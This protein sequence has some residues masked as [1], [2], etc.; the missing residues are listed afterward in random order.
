MSDETGSDIIV[1]KERETSN[2]VKPHNDLLVI[3]L[4]IANIDVARILVNTGSS[5]DIVFKSTLERMKLT[6]SKIMESPIPLVGLSRET[7][8]TLGSI[9]LAVKAM[10]IKKVVEFLIIDCPASYN[11]IVGT[12]WLN[13]MQAILS[14]YHMFL[15]FPTPRR[16]ETIWG[17]RRI[18]QICFVAELK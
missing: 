13:S 11:A 1:S 15:K 2:K 14:T 9:S 17:D 3:E 7:T 4:T 10:R 8:M 6:Y 5:I 12:P 18:L 16:T